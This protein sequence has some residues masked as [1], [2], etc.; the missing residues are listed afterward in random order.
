M[1]L[2][3]KPDVVRAVILDISGVYARIYDQGYFEQD[4][5]ENIKQKYSNPNIW[6]I[7]VL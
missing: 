7:L 2:H 6:R 4:A 3:T 5:F 1:I